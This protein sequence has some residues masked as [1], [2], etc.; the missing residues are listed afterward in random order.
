MV[1]K[2]VSKS[3]RVFLERSHFTVLPYHVWQ[4]P[5]QE[6]RLVHTHTHLIDKDEVEWHLD[7]ESLYMPA[8]KHNINNDEEIKPRQTSKLAILHH[9]NSQTFPSHGVY[10]MESV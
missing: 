7:E 8:S 9:E 5:R 2:T 4:K 10:S 3:S 1:T 6:K